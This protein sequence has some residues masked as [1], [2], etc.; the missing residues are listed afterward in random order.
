MAH[1][2][3]LFIYTSPNSHLHAQTPMRSQKKSGETTKETS[4]VFEEV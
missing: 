3:T 1:F 2:F 4:N